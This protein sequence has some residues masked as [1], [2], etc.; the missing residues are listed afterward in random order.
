MPLLDFAGRVIVV[1]GAGRGMG[2]AHATELA[3]RGA[4]VIVNDLGADLSGRGRDE[5]PAEQVAMA[6]R[7]EGGDAVAHCGTVATAS[8]C[9]ALV[10]A[11]VGAYGRVDGVLHNAGN[12]SWVPVARMRH[13]A[14]DEVLR[15]HVH[16]AVYLTRAAWP[17]LC[18][19]GRIL[20]IT[21]GAA[22]YGT[23]TLAHYACAKAGLVG[24]ARVVAAEGRSDAIS[25]NALAV[26]AATRMM[27]GVLAE[28]PNLRDWFAR[29]LPA[30]LPSAAAVWLLHPDC[31]ASGNV[32]EAYGPH[33]ARVLVAETSGFTKLDMTAEDVRDH[34]DA[35]EAGGELFV[36]DDVDD[37]NRGMFDFIVRAGADPP[38]PDSLGK[39]SLLPEL[40]R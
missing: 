24:L 18:G 25:A 34:F 29:Y 23:P 13:T 2:A 37:F 10:A 28:A 12:V 31:P 38:Q 19:G 17:H 9:D 6:I 40:G 27:D 21:S 33:V 36:P 39:E 11:A 5:D 7:A 15:V 14:L 35:V 4:R 30:H 8:G 3:R 1:T 26:C 16:G 20:Y 22:L 32:Y